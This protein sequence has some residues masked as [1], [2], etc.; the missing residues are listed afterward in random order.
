M[1]DLYFWSTP[2]GY[3]VS[4][5]LEELAMPYNVIPVH[6]GKGQQFAP[7]FLAVSP[8]NK[9]PAI[10]DHDGPDGQAISMFES[11]AIMMYLAEKSGYRFMP[12]DTR[13][14]YQVVQWLMFQMGGVGPM[15]GQAHHFRKYAPEQIAYAIDRYTNEARR[16]YT[17]IDRRLANTEYL[18]GEYSIADMA[19][20]PWLRAHKWQGQDLADYPNL[21]RWYSAVR[22]RPAVQRGIAVLEEK[23][24]KT[25]AKPG[26]ERWDNLFGKGQF[27][28][29]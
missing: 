1:I 9:I 3:K 26:G 6:L 28:A 4:I 21:Q 25:G 14:R 17:V 16:L 20:Y 12:Q 8:N 5:L 18:A 10:I 29:R 24:D 27:A 11:G 22:D 13:R 2:N 19:T 15:L 7:E 23:V